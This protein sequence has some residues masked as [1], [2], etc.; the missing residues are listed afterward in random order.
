MA[1]TTAVVA[2]TAGAVSHHQQQKYAN[3]AAEQQAVAGEQQLE[4]QVAAQQAQLDAMA[5]QQAAPAPAAAAAPAAG[6]DMEQLKQLGELHT[7]G[8]LSDEEFAAAKAKV[9][10]GG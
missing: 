1:A 8:V 4:A 3:Q 2:G 6:I 5:A 7:A 9:L 10:A